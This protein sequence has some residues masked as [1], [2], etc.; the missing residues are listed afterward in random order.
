M[1]RTISFILL[2]LCVFLF[3][4]KLLN[5][6]GP[7]LMP[8]AFIISGDVGSG[9]EVDLWRTPA[10][11]VAAVKSKRADFYILPI[12]MAVNLYES[13]FDLVLL[14]VHEWKVFYLVGRENIKGWRDLKGKEVYV[15][16]SRG[17][18]LDVM[19]RMF[20]RKAGLEPDEDVKL[21]YAQPPEIVALFKSGK[22][23]FAALPEPFVTM[24]GGKVLIDFQKE[25]SRLTGLPERIPIAGLFT[26][27]EMSD[28]K[29]AGYVELSLKIS[30]D[31][32]N[33]DPS[34][35]AEIVS[36]V[37]GMPKEILE[38]SVSRMIFEYVSSEDCK[39]EVEVFLKI[40][41]R[42]YPKGLKGIPDENFYK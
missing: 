41:K 26:S 10:E 31:L 5:P 37:I 8:I 9:I 38:R 7:T 35:A 11:A 28:T 27:K 23:N 33:R 22:V 13:G 34:R 25:W 3:S 20:L 19:L 18:V 29:N 15:A 17:T 36:K 39:K 4:I 21:L 30:T 12:T 40:L 2:L 14:G 42:E 24:T 16:H 1:R 32:M 6:F